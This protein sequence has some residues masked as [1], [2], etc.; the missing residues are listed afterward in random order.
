MRAVKSKQVDNLPRVHG[1]AKLEPPSLL[2]VL[3][4][5]SSLDMGISSCEESGIKLHSPRNCVFS[6]IWTQVSLCSQTHQKN[7]FSRDFCMVPLQCASWQGVCAP[8]LCPHRECGFSPKE[9]YNLNGSQ[10]LSSPPQL[11]ALRS[12]VSG[13]G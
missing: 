7:V 5:V 9:V 4:F 6:Y 8:L 12:P 3:R 13:T 11:S 1:R 2:E 10:R